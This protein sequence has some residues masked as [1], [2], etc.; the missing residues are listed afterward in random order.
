MREKMLASMLQERE[1]SVVLRCLIKAYFKGLI[2]LQEQKYGIKLLGKN[3]HDDV[4]S[5]SQ[6]W[7][8]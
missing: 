1:R 6:M 4:T 8:F 3:I 5:T 2:I 7:R